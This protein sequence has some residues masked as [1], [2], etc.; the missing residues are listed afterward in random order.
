M[1]REPHITEAIPPV[2]RDLDTAAPLHF[3]AWAPTALVEPDGTYRAA[4]KACYH[5]PEIGRER[6]DT[7]AFERGYPNPNLARK[8]ARE[9]RHQISALNPD[10]K[11][12]CL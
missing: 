9:L 6:R 11:G 1:Q 7:V 8:R 12:I 2:V 3:W 10:L 5:D 4:V